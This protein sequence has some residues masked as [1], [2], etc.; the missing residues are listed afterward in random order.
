MGRENVRRQFKEVYSDICVP[1]FMVG[2]NIGIFLLRCM[3]LIR[4]SLLAFGVSDH[5]GSTVENILAL[6]SDLSLNPTSGTF[7]FV[8]FY[9]KLG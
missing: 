7:W 4:K 9:I 8:S 3:W 6:K 1:D 5:L 2:A